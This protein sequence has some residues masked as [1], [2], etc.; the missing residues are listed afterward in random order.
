[1]QRNDMRCNR[2]PGRQH[3]RERNNSIQTRARLHASCVALQQRQ[4]LHCI[5]ALQAKYKQGRGKTTVFQLSCVLSILHIIESFPFENTGNR[6]IL[7]PELMKIYCSHRKKTWNVT[8]RRI[9]SDAHPA[10]GSSI[11]PSCHRHQHTYFNTPIQIQ[12][13]P[14]Y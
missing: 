2:R 5:V 10:A 8:A 1:M 9:L 4:H 12:S 3:T 11:E 14:K 13:T 6:G 7:T